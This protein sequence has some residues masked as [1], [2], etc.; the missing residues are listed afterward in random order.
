MFQFLTA[1]SFTLM[2]FAFVLTVFSIDYARAGDFSIS[3]G[4]GAPIG[5][6]DHDH[7]VKH[8]YYNRGYV[9]D[10]Y[11]RIYIPNHH[12]YPPKHY[13]KPNSHHYFSHQDFGRHKSYSRHQPR[14]YNRDY[15]HHRGNRHFRR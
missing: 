12:Y 1:K 10:R 3:I 4:I 2:L 5:Y 6:Y 11:G 13:Y 7:G 15:D 8:H 14:G 9:I